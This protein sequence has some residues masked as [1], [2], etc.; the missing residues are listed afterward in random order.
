[1]ERKYVMKLR[2][3]GFFAIALLAS[4]ARLPAQSYNLTDLGAVPGEK[5]SGGYGVNDL[6]QAAGVSS[7]P[8]GAIATLFSNGKAINLGTLE[9]LD[10]AVATAINGSGEVAGYE[11]FSST[12][13]NV[14]H[15]FLYS[16]GTMTDIH[17]ASLFPA[18]TMAEGING[19]GVVVG[20][21][22]LTSSSFH[23]F[24]YANGRMVDLGPAGAYQASATAINDSGQVVGNYYSTTSGSGAFLY[25][26]GKMNNLGTP[27]GASAVS[28]FAINGT[29]QIAGEIYFTSTPSP[30]HLHTRPSTAMASGPIWVP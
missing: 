29:G 7:N 20:Q 17:S 3:A 15:A 1:M 19:S 25:S 10:V 16:N 28:A 9:P 14:S 5:V 8:N 2:W 22:L 24:L 6:G 4:T 23:A 11:F 27:A 13:N 12:A 21:G 30:A 26:N 18:G